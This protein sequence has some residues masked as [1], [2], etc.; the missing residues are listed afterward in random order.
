MMPADQSSPRSA[1][2]QDAD[3]RELTGAGSSRTFQDHRE[4]QRQQHF[5]CWKCAAAAEETLIMLKQTPAGRNL[6]RIISI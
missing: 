5:F 4:K 2:L 3:K 1:Q 6:N